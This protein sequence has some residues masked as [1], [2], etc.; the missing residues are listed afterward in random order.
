VL[1]LRVDFLPLS[2]TLEV[3]L[4]GTER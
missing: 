1:T 2:I 3:M 4:F